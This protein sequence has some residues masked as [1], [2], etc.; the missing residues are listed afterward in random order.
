MNLQQT[1][2]LMEVKQ[3]IPDDEWAKEEIGKK[4]KKTS[5]TK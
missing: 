4:V 5:G 2:K 1:Y 3:I